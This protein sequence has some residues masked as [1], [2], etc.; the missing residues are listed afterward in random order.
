MHHAYVYEGSQNQLTDLALDARTYFHFKGMHDPDVHVQPYEKFGIEDALALKASAFL[1]TVSGRA[2]YVVG[3]A[4]ISSEAQQALLKLFEEPQAGSVF[5]LLVPHGSLIR[6][7]RSRLL[8]Y[9][10]ALGIRDTMSVAAKK[11]LSAP[12]KVRS[13]AVSELLHDEEGVRERVRDFLNALE[14][15][16]YA[17]LP[18]S[19]DVKNIRESLEDIAKIRSYIS[20]RSPSLKML[21][22]HLAMATPKKIAAK[23]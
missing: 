1:K 18:R 15:E 17:A 11:F 7:L 22:E 21:L 23:R 2:L 3:A 16:L 6:T 4:A 19:E 8:D 14:I 10:H 12:A 13:A 9:P 20:D 5:V